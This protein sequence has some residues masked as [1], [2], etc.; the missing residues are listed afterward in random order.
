MFPLGQ[1]TLAPIIIYSGLFTQINSIYLN[2]IFHSRKK[3]CLLWR[4]WWITFQTLQGLIFF[5][6]LRKSELSSP[7]D[8]LPPGNQLNW[9]YSH[10]VSQG[11]NPPYSPDTVHF[12]S[13][14]HWNGI[15]KFM[16]Y[17]CTVLMIVHFSSFLVEKLT[18]ALQWLFSSP[19]FLLGTLCRLGL[20]ISF[21]IFFYKFSF[22]LNKGAESS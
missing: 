9:S 15:L 6:L 20:N 4:K 8:N 3:K 14:F 5:Q 13:F 11:L 2:L 22:T 1:N 17:L 16:T 7:R 21:K 19:D 18:P 10:T 12:S